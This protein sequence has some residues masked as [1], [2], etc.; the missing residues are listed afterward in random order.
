MKFN[1]D[2]MGIKEIQNLAKQLRIP[3]SYKEGGV[4]F[5]KNKAQLVRDIKRAMRKQGELAQ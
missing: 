4:R 5:R 1:I 3:P 2:D